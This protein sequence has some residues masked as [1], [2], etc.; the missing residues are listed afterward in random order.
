[1]SAATTAWLGGAL[2]LFAS[3]YMGSGYS[4]VVLQFPGA[5]KSV[6]A[7]NFDDR[8]GGPIRRA[9]ITWTVMVILM[10]AGGIVLTVH[11]WDH[12]GYRYGP[13]VYV[14]ATVVATAWTLLIIFPVNQRLRDADDDPA[15]F[16]RALSLWMKLSVVRFAFWVTEWLAITIWLV[17]LA[18]RANR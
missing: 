15:E 6:N 8:L 12:G 16:T 7:G 5:L 13:L 14:V 4:L 11:E 17:A 10:V 3:I 9:T 2:V 18:G 1:M